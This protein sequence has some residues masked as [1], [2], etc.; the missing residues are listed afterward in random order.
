M[1][2]TIETKSGNFVYANKVSMTEK[3]SAKGFNAESYFKEI[4]KETEQKVL[5]YG[6][7]TS[8]EADKYAKAMQAKA[9]YEFNLDKIAAISEQYDI[10]YR[11]QQKQ[12]T[13]FKNILKPKNIM[14]PNQDV[15]SSLVDEM[16]NLKEKAV[17]E[18]VEAN[19]KLE[20][21]Y[22]EAL[23]LRDRNNALWDQYLAARKAE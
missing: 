15:K 9:D 14:D 1:S 16:K 17:S 13:E 2:K 10:W 20:K 8:K 7:L 19:K 12:L 22:K 4:A 21:K 3:V 23:K 6:E 18:F 5:Q 11:E